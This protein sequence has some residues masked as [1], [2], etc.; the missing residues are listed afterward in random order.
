MFYQWCRIRSPS[1]QLFELHQVIF[2]IS[3]DALRLHARQGGYFLLVQWLYLINLYSFPWVS[4]PSITSSSN[5]T[6]LDQAPRYKFASP[7]NN[8]L[9]QILQNEWTKIQT[10]RLLTKTKARGEKKYNIPYTTGLSS[11]GLLSASKNSS[12]GLYPVLAVEAAAAVAEEVSDL[13]AARNVLP[14][15][16]VRNMAAPM[17][18]ESKD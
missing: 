4:G 9:R 16:R 11:S 12:S 8:I 13:A 5:F 17:L 1:D 7:K 6:T 18:L 10:Y 3:K 14:N 2:V 15:T